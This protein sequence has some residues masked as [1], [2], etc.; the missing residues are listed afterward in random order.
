MNITLKL[1]SRKGTFE[2]H[3][4][5]KSTFAGIE[6]LF[7]SQLV[8]S[9]VIGIISRNFE[10]FL[11]AHQVKSVIKIFRQILEG[12]PPDSVSYFTF[13]RMGLQRDSY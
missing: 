12:S 2:E 10:Y 13:L 5:P 8:Y 7:G 9:F 11:T 3:E 4:F 6:E 1:I